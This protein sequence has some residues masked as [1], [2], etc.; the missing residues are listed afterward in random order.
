MLSG[1][2]FVPLGENVTWLTWN[3]HNTKLMLAAR[4]AH[5]ALYDKDPNSFNVPC[6]TENIWQDSRMLEAYAEYMQPHMRLVAN[7]A[8]C[9]PD[10]FKTKRQNGIPLSTDRSPLDI[11][12]FSPL[13][14][15]RQ[16]LLLELMFHNLNMS[17]Y[18]PFV[19]FVPGATPTPLADI[20]AMKCAEHGMA[21]THIMYQIICTTTILAGWH[22]AFQWQWNAA[23]TLIG[24]V[25][26][27]PLSALTGAAREAIDLSVAVFETFG[28]SFA[29]AASAANITRELSAK[30]DLLIERNQLSCS[31]ADS[32]DQPA[33]LPAEGIPPIPITTA[34]AP[35]T[36][37]NLINDFNPTP[38]AVDGLYNFDGD[39]VAA[40]QGYL[41][42]SISAMMGVEMYNSFDADFENL[43]TNAN[44]N[45]R[46]AFNG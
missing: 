31:V 46:W 35:C 28:N 43:M 6:T 39:A 33:Q 4:A 20:S 1:S 25:L 8:R 45:D 29:I 5:S 18:R 22:E 37:T 27:N 36:E 32:A 11:E 21:L 26:A 38:Q 9:V 17:L 3:I 41:N 30:V 23:V 44:T 19:S 15:Q 7:W 10:V 13:W 42:Q 14:L 24:F 16:R 12:Q 34:P 2:S 40:M